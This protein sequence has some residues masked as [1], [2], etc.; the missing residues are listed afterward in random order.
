M[1]RNKTTFLKFDVDAVTRIID[2]SACSK[3]LIQ[4]LK[5]IGSMSCI[6]EDHY[7]DRHYL[8]DFQEYYSRSFH[9]PVVSCKRLH[10]FNCSAS[11]L[12]KLF[13]NAYSSES[14]REQ[15]ENDLGKNYLGFSVIRPLNYARIGRT[16]LKTYPLNGFRHIEVVRPYRVHISG[17]SLKVNGLAFQQQDLGAAV[18]ASTALW[19]ALQRVS[20]VIGNRTPTPT[21]ITKAAHSPLSACFGLTDD[22]MTFALSSLGFNADYFAPE[23]NHI[24]FKAKIAACLQSQLPVILLLSKQ[25]QTGEFES[26][27][28]HAVTI[29]GYR[30]PQEIE[31]V[32]TA[33][34]L[35]IPMKVGSLRDI[36]VHDDNFGCHAHYELSSSYDITTKKMILNLRRGCCSKLTPDDWIADY[37]DVSAALVPKPDKMRMPIE[38]L[39]N[40]LIEI[41]DLISLVLPETSLNFSTKFATGIEYKRTL[42]C[43]EFDNQKLAKFCMTWSLPRYIGVIGVMSEDLLICDLVMD[44][45][46]VSRGDIKVFVIG[47]VSSFVSS[48]S[49]AGLNLKTICDC[50]DI[51]LLLKD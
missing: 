39:F 31:D 11:K 2:E 40:G 49:L 17:I 34:D 22:Q 42:I 46:E 26:H 51:P 32:I 12:K 13:L 27:L 16:V 23:Q 38:Q 7:I 28:G 36:Y 5:E 50:F 8:E 19:C 4:Y 35:H 37:W 9:P 25:I 45:S 44:I 3:Y 18:C 30:E 6:L 20:Y 47:I 33:T 41:R 14:D 29:T 15:V 48:N 1:P 10:F 24:L 21:A 43:G